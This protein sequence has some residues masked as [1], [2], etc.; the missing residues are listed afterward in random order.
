MHSRGRS[1]LKIVKVILVV[2]STLFTL[3][4]QSYAT[5]VPTNP[6]LLSVNEVNY[7]G[8]ITQVNET[9]LIEHIKFFS[10]LS[11]RVSGYPGFYEAAS[12]IIQRFEK[13]GLSCR[14]QFFNVT[15]PIDYGG[16]IE[17]LDKDYSLTIKAYSVW[18]NSVNIAPI[19]FTGDVVYVGEG[20]LSNFNLMDIEGK[21][22]LM[23]FNSRWFWKNAALLGAKAV[24]FIEPEDTTRYEAEQKFT[25]IPI[26]FPRMYIR[27]EDGLTILDILKKK[28]SLTVKV[29]SNMRWEEKT[30][31]NIIA[32]VEGSL[33]DE[34][35][36]FSAYYD[37]FSCVPSISPGASESVGISVLLELADFFSKNKPLRTIYFVAFASHWQGMLGGRIF[38][39]ELFQSGEIS[40]IK[41]FIHLDLS[42][43]TDN[44]I[45]Y[46]NVGFSY[47]FAT[48][49]QAA[50]RPLV[51]RIFRDYL[52]TLER[53][54]GRKYNLIDGIYFAHPNF[55]PPPI[56]I[57]FM[58]EADLATM[59]L[60]GGGL[61]IHTTNT[62]RPYLKTPLDIFNR[63]ELSNLKP[64]AEVI[65]FLAYSIV[66][67][68]SLPSIVS[69]QRFSFNGD[70]GYATL[71]IQAAV[72]DPSIDWFQPFY[73]PNLLLH[74]FGEGL[75]IVIKPDKTGRALIYGA[76]PWRIYTVE[77]YVVEQGTGEVKYAT[78]MGIFGRRSALALIN[79]SKA[80]PVISPHVKK[81]I[82]LFE[83]GS[84]VLLNLVNPQ[85]LGNVTAV[86]VN[87]FMSH[88]EPLWY[89][90]V[91]WGSDF[92]IFVSP[93][94]RFEI[95]IHGAVKS[96]WPLG[97]LI[98][99]TENNPS[100]EGYHLSPGQMLILK[101]L[102]L[103]ICKDLY[104]TIIG[105]GEEMIRNRILS[106]RFETFFSKALEYFERAKGDLLR[107]DYVNSYIHSL[108]AWSLLNKAYAALMDLR[109][110]VVRTIA[111]FSPM[112]ILFSAILS[113]VFKP[114]YPGLKRI[115]SILI[116]FLIFWLLLY[117]IHPGFQ[118]ASN[119]LI[120]LSAFAI[121]MILCLTLAIL[122]E[123]ALRYTKEIQRQ[124]LG[125][126]RVDISRTSFAAAALSMGIEYMRKRAFRAT[127][128]LISLIIFVSSLVA[129]TSLSPVV[130]P[131]R[132]NIIGLSY[133]EGL[134]M[135][136]YNV[137]AIPENLYTLLKDYSE[138]KGGLVAART[139]IYPPRLE[140]R[141]APYYNTTFRA[142]LA[143]DSSIINLIPEISYTLYDG[144]WFLP[145]DYNALIID[146]SMAEKLSKDSNQTVKV[147]SKIKLLGYTF[148]IVGLIDGD[149]FDKILDLNQVAF[150][151]PNLA[152]GGG[153]MVEET[154]LPRLSSKEVLI[155]PYE[156]V[157]RNLGGG[158]WALSVSF[159]DS[160]TIESLSQ[161]LSLAV[162]LDIYFSLK[163][164]SNEIITVIRPVVWQMF[165][166]IDYLALVITI[167][168]LSV[169]N[170]MLGAIYER[171]REIN[172]LTTIGLSPLHISFLF[173]SESMVYAVL[174][175]IAGY[176]IGVASLRLL[177]SANAIPQGICP[178]YTSLI[179][180]V[181]VGIC[182]AVTLLSTI[183]P[184]YKSSKL[185]VPSIT[186]RW[187]VSTKPLEY[188]QWSI[189]L[190]FITTKEEL[191]GIL[192]FL[193]EFLELRLREPAGVFTT[194]D[195]WFEKIEGSDVTNCIAAKM[196]MAPYD[197]GIYQITRIIAVPSGK[198]YNLNLHCSRISGP[199]ELWIESTKTFASEIRLQLLIW[200]SF[201]QKEKEKYIKMTRVT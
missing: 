91:S 136:R 170:M 76:K 156:W 163:K 198:F 168:A 94:E 41:Y 116:L 63:L 30:V 49:L 108:L 131:F 175:S 54:S 105:R 3:T 74:V 52:P 57:Q 104:F 78:D 20:L 121:M 64:Q 161:D 51:E 201:S 196:W 70:W 32:C 6:S 16:T 50:Y 77:G 58:S 36:I 85:Q 111:F 199:P 145:T 46:H 72:Y 98:N 53:V 117:I 132:N 102:P 73:D 100:G 178:N 148:T 112:L 152:L 79:S 118:I 44:L 151:P 67:D 90:I 28:G 66:N 119:T 164:G 150:L 193:K 24:I 181:S 93:K 180:L 22:V 189:P 2:I 47:I 134:L 133:Y 61:T 106:L 65:F 92:I 174:S 153:E 124:S 86:T 5:F 84:I 39:E 137:S 110:D 17:I 43:D 172:I 115:F 88:Y 188:E 128:L 122:S 14:L 194:L 141:L 160:N 173:L 38:L 37:S 186:R 18:P 62:L 59:A 48:S 138:E 12:Y 11:S 9:R 99:A 95:I 60:Y 143:V 103:E 191:P 69:P 142:I 176:I 125:V 15:V 155:I 80:I 25:N 190:P 42:S 87:N 120:V 45:V 165:F 33:K 130:V 197:A 35:V 97:F 135:K 144:R 185:S 29:K 89:N 192:N 159:K 7:S 154:V 147:G 101:N 81:F 126:H 55:H 127:L 83:C 10:G 27:R 129:L 21:I 195:V 114:Q 183:Y 26:N 184:S 140:M 179:V 171:T 71:E 56:E 8:L 13:S 139:Y 40:R 34:Y 82:P 107:K 113:Y 162:N 169:L 149:I 187:R 75:N 158:P 166:G 157:L 123:D 167:V 177:I 146:R 109:V 4:F 68:E 200:R 96:Q 23:D 19:D 31:A 182:M 1:G